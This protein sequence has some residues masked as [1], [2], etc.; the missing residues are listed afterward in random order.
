MISYSALTA[1]D[2]A[3]FEDLEEAL[4]WHYQ[5][6]GSQVRHFSSFPCLILCF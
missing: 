1:Q 5:E 4:E 2:A 3:L 6:F